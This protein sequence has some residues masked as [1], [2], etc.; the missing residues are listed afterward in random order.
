MPAHFTLVSLALEYWVGRV[1][2]ILRWLCG[3]NTCGC[4][5]H[6]SSHHQSGKPSASHTS[7]AFHSKHRH[8]HLYFYRCKTMFPMFIR[9]LQKSFE[10]FTLW[11]LLWLTIECLLLTSSSLLDSFPW[12]R[13]LGPW[14]IE[15]LGGG[16]YHGQH[17]AQP[18]VTPF[19]RKS[20]DRKTKM[21]K[22]RLTWS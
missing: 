12:R 9:S 16:Q 13:L 17:Q 5:L 15:A 7:L 2:P 20:W 10:A 14:S 11:P 19:W 22:T 3:C 8:P 18:P 6:P 21:R 1:Q 4:S